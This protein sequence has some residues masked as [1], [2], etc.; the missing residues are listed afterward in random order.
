MLGSECV[1]KRKRGVRDTITNLIVEC[2][3]IATV[4]REQPGIQERVIKPGI[5]DGALVVGSAING[6]EAKF[7]VPSLLQCRANA[8]EVPI[9]NLFLQIRARLL[10]TDKRCS[11]T[12]FYNFFISGAERSISTDIVS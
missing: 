6:D 12:D 5:K 2:T 8:L 10:D 7:L 1:P 4:F 3:V 9:R 11:D